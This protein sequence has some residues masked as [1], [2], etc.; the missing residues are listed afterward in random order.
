LIKVCQTVGGIWSEERD[1]LPLR[2][3]IELGKLVAIRLVGWGRIPYNTRIIVF[4]EI[5]LGLVSGV[6]WFVRDLVME[7]RV[8]HLG[9][10]LVMLVDGVDLQVLASIAKR[11]HL[12]DFE[13]ADYWWVLRMF[14]SLTM[15][16]KLGLLFYI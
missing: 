11:V 13:I 16:L 9:V 15:I 4:K 1:F 3:N 2:M 10:L 5:V 14:L 8:S 6:V 12:T 7:E